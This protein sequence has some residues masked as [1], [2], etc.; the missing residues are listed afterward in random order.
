MVGLE[1]SAEHGSHS[2]YSPG[3]VFE[4][5]KTFDVPEEYRGKRVTFQ[6]VIQLY[7]GARCSKVERA[8]KA[9]KPTFRT[10]PKR[11]E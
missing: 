2:R 6:E 3:G 7:V 8:P 11:L 4:Y 5:I 1:R 9:L 10:T